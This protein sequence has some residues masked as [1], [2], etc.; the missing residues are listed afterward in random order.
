MTL[1]CGERSNLYVVSLV[2]FI[3]YFS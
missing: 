1:L 3:Y 2:D